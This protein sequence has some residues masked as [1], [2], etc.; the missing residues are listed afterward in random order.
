MTTN[1]MTMTD[2]T[3]TFNNLLSKKLAQEIL[4]KLKESYYC[5]MHED[6]EVD[7]L[8]FLGLCV[9]VNAKVSLKY[10]ILYEDENGMH[11]WE[12]LENEID[13]IAINDLFVYDD[14]EE[15]EFNETQ[16]KVLLS[17]LEAHINKTL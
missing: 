8:D 17:F 3:K 11:D 2:T 5:E 7:D 15:I 16:K 4:S 13:N 9:Y 10:N 12:V 14:G 6:V 1:L